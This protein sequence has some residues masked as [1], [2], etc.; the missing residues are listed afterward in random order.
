MKKAVTLVAILG[1]L[2]AASPA[3]ANFK[4]SFGFAK[5][6]LSRETAGVCNGV[7]GCKNWSVRPCLRRSL[8]R[9]DCRSNFFFNDGS[10]CTYVGTA[11]LRFHG[12]FEVITHHKRISCPR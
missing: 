3:S 7:A 9:I 8:H 1:L 11:T 10:Y 4:L 5:R 6:E 12:Q 2:I